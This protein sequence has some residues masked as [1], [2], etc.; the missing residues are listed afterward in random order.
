MNIIKLKTNPAIFSDVLINNFGQ[1]VNDM[2][3]ENT[4]KLQAIYRPPVEL[5][6][7]NDHY[8]LQL[9][10]PGVTKQN[11]SIS[12]EDHIIKIEA[13]HSTTASAYKV[14]HSEF[15]QGKYA[16]EVR[17]PKNVSLDAISAKLQDGILTVLVQKKEESKPK[18]IR[19][20]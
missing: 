4:D 16:R 10:L 11:I 15:N 3:S 20:A 8:M 14:L 9:S 6:E 19:I 2:L 13:H 18:S 17:L 5:S 7:N 1:I 12:Q